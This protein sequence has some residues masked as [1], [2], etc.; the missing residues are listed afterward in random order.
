MKNLAILLAA[1]AALTAC[2]GSSADGGGSASDVGAMV[3][4]ATAGTTAADNFTSHV[5]SVVGSS[6]DTAEPEAVDTASADMP[7]DAEP[8]PVS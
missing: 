2:G 3:E 5:A 8:T 1:C 4:P 7:E 6:S